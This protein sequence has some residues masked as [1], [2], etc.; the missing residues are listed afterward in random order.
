M[1]AGIPYGD[2]AYT[3]SQG[4]AS[5]GAN[6]GH[7]GTSVKTLLNNI[8]S[9]ADFS[10][11]SVH[12]GVVIGKKITEIFYG[13][14]HTK[15][16]YLRCSMGGRQG[17]KEAQD[18]PADFDGIIAGAPAHALGNLTSWTGHF[19]PLTGNVTSPRFVPKAMWP[20]I[21]RDIYTQCD[22][23]D[24]AVDG[25]I[26]TAEYCRYDPSGLVCKD[27]QTKDCLTE[28]QAE[29]V[30]KIYSPLFDSHGNFV[31]PAMNPGSEDS[32]A[33]IWFTGAPVSLSYELIRL[34]MLLGREPFW[35]QLLERHL[36]PF[37]NRGGKVITYHGQMD[38]IITSGI[39]ETYYEHVSRSMQSSPKELDEFYRF[40]RIGG[41]NHCALGSGAWNFGQSGPTTYMDADHNVL[42]AIVRWVEQGIAPEALTGTKYINDTVSLGK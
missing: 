21:K 24:G 35:V 40:F 38:S 25:V 34:S 18:F 41:M 28:E 6:S 8:E 9:T 2:M 29:T 1:T 15:S 37:R 14:P 26:E 32:T 3:M 23:L 22:G 42:A 20:I 19:Y 36:S 7:N 16:Y 10:Y 39:S 13:Q 4:F 27:G 30:R 5:V 31:Y 11:R 12:T 33:S 17:F